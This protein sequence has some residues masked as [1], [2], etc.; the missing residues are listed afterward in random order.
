MPST[1]PVPIEHRMAVVLL[2]EVLVDGGSLGTQGV[3]PHE[4]AEEERHDDQRERQRE[5]HM[6]LS[7][8]VRHSVCHQQVRPC[9]R[10][11]LVA[12]DAAAVAEAHGGEL[13]IQRRWC[14]A[15]APSSTARRLDRTTHIVADGLAVE[16]RGDLRQRDDGPVALLLDK[17]RIHAALEPKPTA[18]RA[19]WAHTTVPQSE[20][21]S[22]RRLDVG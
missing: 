1:Q 10:R 14:G 15:V 19:E 21:K 17:Q 9:T 20:S 6:P 4:C 3:A 13:C 8:L 18:A 5:A 22:E 16:T 12:Q 2:V 11:V 7:L